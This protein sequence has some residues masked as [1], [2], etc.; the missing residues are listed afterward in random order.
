MKMGKVMDT[1][2]KVQAINA[3][4]LDIL[5]DDLVRGGMP[6]SDAAVAVERY[7]SFLIAV[8]AYPTETIIPS[9]LVDKVWHAHML[10]PRVYFE[11]CMVALGQIVDHTPGVYGTPA[12]EAAYAM[13]RKLVSYGHTMPVDPYADHPMA[14]ADCWRREPGE[15]PEWPLIRQVDHA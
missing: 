13:T 14:G 10:R 6:K 11:D 12:Y 1:L 15:D 2:S 7:R 8:A 5:V 9:K 4:N 3:M